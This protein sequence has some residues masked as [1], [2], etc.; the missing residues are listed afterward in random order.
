MPD[1]LGWLRDKLNE[2][3]EHIKF[4]YI[5]DHSEEAVILLFGKFN[6]ILKPGLH[7]KVPFIE[8]GNSA[9]IKPD[10]IEI[11]SICITTLDGKTVMAGLVIDFDI[12]DVKKYLWENTDS[13]SNLRNRARGELSSK[14]EDIEWAEIKKKV[15]KNAIFKKISEYADT[16]GIRILNVDYTNK[17]EVRAYRLFNEEKKDKI[18]LLT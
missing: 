11:E 12:I 14:L 18:T 6:R 7:L 8:V 16:L 4:W 3:W 1:I 15:T 5:V 17:C 2:F 13:P 10:N 9:H